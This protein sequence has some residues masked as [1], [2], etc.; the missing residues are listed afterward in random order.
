VAKKDTEKTKVAAIEEEHETLDAPENDIVQDEDIPEE[1][2]EEEHDDTHE[3]YHEDEHHHEHAS[4]SSSILRVL[5]ILAIGAAT[6]LWV[7]PKIAPKLPA[8]LKPIAEFLSPQ[9]DITEQVAALQANFAKRL[10]EIEAANNQSDAT[11]DIEPK[12]VQLATKDTEIDTMVAELSVSVKALEV[13]IETLQ[14]EL[15]EV[16]ALQAL[17]AQGGQASDEALQQFEEKLAAISSA[18]LKLNKSQLIA[19]EAQQSA[20]DKLRLADATNAVS[21]ISDALETGQAYQNEL[22]QLSGISGIDIP[23]GL[24]DSAASGAP[25]LSGLKKQLPE[26]SRIVLREDA[27]TKAGDDVVGKFTAFL[28]SQVGTRSLEPK[29]GDDMDAVLSRIEATL[30]ADDLDAAMVET[31][32]LNDA[33]KQTMADWVASLAKLNGARVALHAVQQQLSTTQR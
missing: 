7:G 19:V 17:T 9:A 18:Q 13:A 29:Q 31:T 28:K 10:A 2:Y 23:P 15:T 16:T 12:L 3:D 21:R 5:A 1:A 27:A 6:A 33:A 26:L 32:K 8:G 14:T 4:L 30:K 22:D 20:E 24:A 25:S 11:A